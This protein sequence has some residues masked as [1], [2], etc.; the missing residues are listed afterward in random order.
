MSGILYIL[1]LWNLLSICSHSPWEFAEAERLPACVFSFVCVCI[2][3]NVDKG[4]LSSVPSGTVVKGPSYWHIPSRSFY[5]AHA[6]KTS[7]TKRGATDVQGPTHKLNYDS[8]PFS[9]TLY[10]VSWVQTRS[11]S[12]RESHLLPGRSVTE[13]P[14]VN[15]FTCVP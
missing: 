15:A 3:E 5:K 6:V 14:D 1:N 7:I 9:W 10:L 12:S 4:L 8:L 2:L 11:H 13:C